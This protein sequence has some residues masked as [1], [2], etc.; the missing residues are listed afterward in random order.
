MAF[1][2]RL[3]L[4]FQARWQERRMQRAKLFLGFR[5]SLPSLAGPLHLSFPALFLLPTPV[6]G[7]DS[8]DTTQEATRQCR[9]AFLPSLAGPSE[10]LAICTHFI[11]Q[12]LGPHGGGPRHGSK[13]H[14]GKVPL[15][16]WEEG[17]AKLFK[18]CPSL[19]P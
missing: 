3:G 12:L 14:L 7:S 9:L 15:G 5:R 16:M 10:N 17:L 2:E 19:V 8:P 11:C 18:E 13:L 4:Y 6:R 1:K